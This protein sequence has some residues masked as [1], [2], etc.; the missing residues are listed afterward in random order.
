MIMIYDPSTGRILSGGVDIIGPR[1]PPWIDLLDPDPAEEVAVQRLLGVDIPSREAMKEIEAS[2]RLSRDGDTLIMTAPILVDSSGLHP[3]NSAVTFILTSVP[4][5]DCL[6]TVR[7]A[8]PGGIAA[9][10]ARLER[11]PA[12][13]PPLT[14]GQVLLDLLEA[15]VDRMADVLERVGG[16]LDIVSHRIFHQTSEDLPRQRSSP[17]ELEVTLRAIG[18]GGDIAAKVRDTL[19]GL[20][21]VVSFLPAADAALGVEDAHGRLKTVGR[22]LQSLSEYADFLDSKIG[23][24]LNATLGMISIQQNHII[25]L[26]SVMAVLFLPPTLVASIY[27]MN[28]SFM[29]ELDKPWG[30]PVALA[31]MVAAALLPY[32]IFKR[33]NWL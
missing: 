20:R 6:V 14:A 27:G 32:W 1:I 17:R 11:A 9:Y 3:R 21:R 25:K 24:L 30:Y 22:D 31:L 2:S 18:R 33:R 8:T 7:T 4:A 19:L 29:P 16:D 12:A 28:F 26:F 13:T 23:F 15:V 10:L 5:G